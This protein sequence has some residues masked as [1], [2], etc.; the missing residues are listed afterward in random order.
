MARPM[1]REAPVTRQVDLRR[2][3]FDEAKSL[4][5]RVCVKFRESAGLVIL[6]ALRVNG[7][8]ESVNRDMFD[9]KNGRDRET[10]DKV[11]FDRI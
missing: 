11:L 4:R 2:A 7:G 3:C 8:S 1:P 10:E 5:D 6:Q 9:K